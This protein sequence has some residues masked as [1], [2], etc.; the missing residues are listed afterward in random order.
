RTTEP[1]STDGRTLL[2]VRDNLPAPLVMQSPVD[3]ANGAASAAAT[4]GAGAAGGAAGAAAGG[5]AS[6]V[7]R[8]PKNS[9]LPD[10]GDRLLAS[11]LATE[12]LQDRVR[13]EPKRT[14]PADDDPPMGTWEGWHVRA[15]I[16][17]LLI[18][19]DLVAAT[20]GMVATDG[21]RPV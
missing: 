7:A 18:S 14:T 5:T 16:R 1:S 13:D 19:L 21:L 6:R 3:A 4:S 20:I 17:P 8:H 11:D 2:D 15:G 12:L 10:E 9:P